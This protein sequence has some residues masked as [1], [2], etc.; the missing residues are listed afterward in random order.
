[1]AESNSNKKYKIA[2]FDIDGILNEHGGN[3]LE[4]SKQAIHKLRTLGVRVCFASG[5]HAWYIQGGL[6]WSGLLEKDT[7]IIGENGGVIFDPHSR[8]NVVDDKFLGD[9]R[10]LRSIFYNLYSSKE[11]FLKFAGMTVWEEPKESLFNLYPQDTKDVPR[12]AKNLREIVE[13]NKLNLYC[14]ENPDSVDVIQEGINKATGIKRVCGWL[15]IT[16]DDVLA[17]GDSYNDTEML[18]EVGFAVTVENG[19]PEIKELV[20]SKGKDH[21]YIASKKCGDGVME[22]IEHLIASKRL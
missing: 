11:G 6:V 7:I 17:F 16:I 20:K 12:L 10:R 5:K 1:M 18:T 15:G 14:V 13:I 22:A 8:K 3:I 9:V 4:S 19:K 21:G 2:M